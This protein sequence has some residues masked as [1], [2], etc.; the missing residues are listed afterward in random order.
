MGGDLVEIR[1][2]E[3]NWNFLY[4]CMEVLRIILYLEIEIC[5]DIDI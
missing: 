3:Y 1:R 5:L 4:L 2:G